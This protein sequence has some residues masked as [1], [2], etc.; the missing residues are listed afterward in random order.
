MQG[1][2]AEGKTS[3]KPKLDL[4]GIIQYKSQLYQE[5]CIYADKVRSIRQKEYDNAALYTYTYAE[6]AEQLKHSRSNFIEYFD[7]V[8]RTMHT[9]SSDSIIFNWRRVHELLKIFAKGDTILFSQI[10]L[11]MVEA[12]RIS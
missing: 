7:H 1:T 12:F 5:S 9:H 6:Q 11:K 2:N 8:Q 3:Y 4:N 10:D